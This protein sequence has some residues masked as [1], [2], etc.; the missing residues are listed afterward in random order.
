MHRSSNLF[1]PPPIILIANPF[2]HGIFGF[3]LEVTQ[4]AVIHVKTDRHL[5]SHSDR[6]ECT[7]VVR[8]LLEPYFLKVLGELAIE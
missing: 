7:G 8:I 5:R 3:L 2:D 6:V 1:F 4:L